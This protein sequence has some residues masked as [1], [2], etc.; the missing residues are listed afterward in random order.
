MNASL[1]ST[2]N[3]WAGNRLADDL[4]IF[5]AKYLLFLAFVAFVVAAARA[6]R[7]RGLSVLAGSGVTLALAFGFG[8]VAAALHTE[9][10]PFQSHHVRLLIMHAPG[11]SF[12][13][14]HATAA[15]ALALA[16]LVFLSRPVGA[17]LLAAAALIGFARVY[18][19]V[20]YPGDIFGSFLISLLALPFGWL[21][22]NRDTWK[23]SARSRDDAAPPRLNAP[24][25]TRA[26]RHHPAHR[27]PPSTRH[28][29]DRLDRRAPESQAGGG[30]LAVC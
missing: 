8:L 7:R 2:I 16:A 22:H 18:C 28:P 25:R 4:M 26:G 20:H 12:P 11:Q 14:D 13:S 1:F 24:G 5:A 21:A 27:L 30:K 29:G 17:A 23:T 3:G 10:R 15:F 19:G 9:R 6:Y